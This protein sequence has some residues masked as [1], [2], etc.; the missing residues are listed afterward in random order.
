ML[1][2]AFLHGMLLYFVHHNPAL[3]PQEK[4]LVEAEV[5][6]TMVYRCRLR[7]YG[8]EHHDTLET[9]GTLADLLRRMRRDDEAEVAEKKIVTA[10]RGLLNGR[11]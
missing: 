5:L 2:P 1:S 7:S 9:L 8:T 6:I 4:R 11:R 10:G 3:C